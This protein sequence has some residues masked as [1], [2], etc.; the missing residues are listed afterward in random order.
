MSSTPGFTVE[1]DD[2]EGDRVLIRVKGEL[3]MAAT[4][5]AHRG[6]R[7]VPRAARASHLDLS[8]VTFLD[9]S[10]IGALVASGREVGEAGSR[11]EIGPR[12][13]I[14]NRVLEITGLGEILRGLR[15]AS[16]GR[17]SVTVTDGPD[18]A[19]RAVARSPPAARPAPRRERGGVAR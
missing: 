5:D 9:S 18:P 4:P 16:R 6:H 10:A 7:R 17:V 11:L 19:A 14:V 15:R 1:I 12:S 8:G 2:P 3:D 13:D